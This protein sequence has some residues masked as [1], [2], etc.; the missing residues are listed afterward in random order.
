MIGEIAVKDSSMGEGFNS[1]HLVG[2]E[3][4]QVHMDCMNAL[5]QIVR[6]EDVDDM[7]G[8]V[9]PIQYCVSAMTSDLVVMRLACLPLL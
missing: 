9:S 7:G 5:G 4:L 6:I 3:R 1:L 8:L 2:S